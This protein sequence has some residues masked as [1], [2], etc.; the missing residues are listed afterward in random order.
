MVVPP[1]AGDASAPPTVAQAYVQ[2]AERTRGR[3]VVT[4]GLAPGD[5][6]VT[7]GQLRLHNGAAVEISAQ[8]TVALDAGTQSVAQAR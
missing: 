7:S 2:T 1:K 6:V 8:D 3:V 4:R 5:Q